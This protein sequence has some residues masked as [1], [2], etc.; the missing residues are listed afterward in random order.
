MK[1]LIKV[2]YK[3]RYFY[4][5]AEKFLIRYRISAIDFSTNK[6][7]DSVELTYSLTEISNRK[8]LSNILGF[9]SDIKPGN[10]RLSIRTKTDHQKQQ[11]HKKQYFDSD[12]IEI[13]EQ[14]YEFF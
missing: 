10:Y 6:P 12:K 7:L 8:P 3:N 14:V 11:S 9:V 4:A 1:V 13:L 5:L 2:K